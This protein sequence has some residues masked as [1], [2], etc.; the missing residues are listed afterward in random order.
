M[1]LKNDFFEL[2]RKKRV[3]KEKMRVQE[4]VGD[5]YGVVIFSKRKS[6]RKQKQTKKKK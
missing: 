5:F 2:W 3:L 4:L 6:C 1:C